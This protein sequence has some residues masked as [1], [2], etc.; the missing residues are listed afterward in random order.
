[1][2]AVDFH[3]FCGGNPSINF[4]LKLDMV[5]LCHYCFAAKLQ[6]RQQHPHFHLP[7]I[8]EL[9]YSIYFSASRFCSQ[10]FERLNIFFDWP[11]LNSV[12]E[13][14]LF[15]TGEQFLAVNVSGTEMIG[16]WSL[17]LTLP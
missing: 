3:V 17:F 6:T 15:H 4:R 16:D 13:C 8:R 12:P 1:M 14:R 7:N 10:F 5:R 11:F 9:V 2:L